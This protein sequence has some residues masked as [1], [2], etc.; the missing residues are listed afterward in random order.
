M[1]LLDLVITAGGDIDK[2]AARLVLPPS[3]GA[4]DAVPRET[5]ALDAS[6]LLRLGGADSTEDANDPVAAQKL[7]G[8]S[9]SPKLSESLRNL[10]ARVSG[11]W[12]SGG[13]SGLFVLEVGGIDSGSASRGGNGEPTGVEVP[14]GDAI[15]MNDPF[16]KEEFRSC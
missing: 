1:P 7:S 10:P 15:A 6:E 5:P 16:K 2:D 11:G 14:V 8:M 13:K 4:G 3:S 12:A 9:D